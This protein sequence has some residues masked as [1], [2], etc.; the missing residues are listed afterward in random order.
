MKFYISF[1]GFLLFVESGCTVYNVIYTDHSATIDFRSYKTFAWLPS[2]NTDNTPYHN[3]IIESNTKNYFTHEFLVRGMTVHLDTPDVLMQ[4]VIKAVSK[5]KTEQ[6]PV[7]LPP[8]NQYN[9]TYYGN[10]YANPYNNSYNYNPY[11]YPAT[12]PQNPYY[13]PYPNQYNYN[14]PSNYNYNNFSNYGYTTKIVDYTESTI[15][16]NIIDRKLNKMVWTATVEGDLYDPSQMQYNLHPA[17][18]RIL[19]SYPIKPIP[20]KKHKVDDIYK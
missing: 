13:S 12:S 1:L 4:L 20:P 11:N 10:P 9:N 17:V 2:D 5:Q 7:S 6:V 16:L 3:Q 14:V 15:T 18:L 19:D 8:I